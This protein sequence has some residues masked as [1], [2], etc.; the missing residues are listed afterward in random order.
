[1]SIEIRGSNGSK[2]KLITEDKIE[3]IIK[4]KEIVYNLYKEKYIDNK[5]NTIKCNLTKNHL[6]KQLINTFIIYDESK[7][8]EYNFKVFKTFLNKVKK[9]INL[10]DYINLFYYQNNLF[11]KLNKSILIILKKIFK[12][13]YEIEFIELNGNFYL[14]LLM[15]IHILKDKNQNTDKLETYINDLIEY[16]ENLMIINIKANNFS[17]YSI[18]NTNNDNDDD[19]TCK[20]IVKILDIYLKNIN[21]IKANILKIDSLLNIIIEE[22]YKFYN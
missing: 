10:I 20:D 13:E 11:E 22:I 5:T 2:L 15:L 4:E 16:V 1:M 6:Y 18:S 17:T 19:I 3:S 21:N 9:S 7:I 8:Y 14:D 12:D